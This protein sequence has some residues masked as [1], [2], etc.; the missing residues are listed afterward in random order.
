MSESSNDRRRPASLSA[1]T[2]NDGNGG[3]GRGRGRLSCVVWPMSPSPH[4][5]GSSSWP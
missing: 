4:W 1:E 5:P 2:D 3:G